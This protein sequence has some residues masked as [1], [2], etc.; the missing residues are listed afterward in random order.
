MPN[1]ERDPYESVN[2]QNYSPNIDKFISFISI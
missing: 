2:G 1:L